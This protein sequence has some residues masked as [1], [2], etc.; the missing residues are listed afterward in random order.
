MNNIPQHACDT[1]WK[2]HTLI[3]LHQIGLRS[4]RAC[5]WVKLSV[6]HL[7]C[8]W[9]WSPNPLI[10]NIINHKPHIYLCLWKKV[11]LFV[12][13]VL[14]CFV[15]HVMRFLVLQCFLTRFLVPIGKVRWVKGVHTKLIFYRIFWPMIWRS[16]L[17]L[18]NNFS[19]ENSLK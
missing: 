7:G 6:I 5:R 19:I 2:L 17:I 14:F 12:C 15:W 18:N 4:W 16:Y 8:N 9:V 11:C 13:F 1:K 3:E 10:L